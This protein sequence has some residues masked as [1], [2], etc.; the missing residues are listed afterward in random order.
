MAHGIRCHA[1]GSVDSCSQR[2][3][4]VSGRLRLRPCADAQ[5]ND[6][7]RRRGS[8]PLAIN[9]F[10]HTVFSGWVLGAVFVVGVSSWLLLKKRNTEAARKSVTVA[11]WVG[12]IGILATLYTGH[13]SAVQGRIKISVSKSK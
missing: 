8:Q 2:M 13:G 9:K 4:A 10:F 5:C 6:R 11:S 3:D 1:V 7:F 12:L